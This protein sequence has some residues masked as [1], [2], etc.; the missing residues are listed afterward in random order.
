MIASPLNPG[1]P[2]TTVT[3][4]ASTTGW[5]AQWGSRHLAG[6]W[7]PAQSSLHI[8]IL[9]MTAVH[10]ALKA[11]APSL[12]GSTVA[13]YADNKTVVAHLL[14]EGGTR[15]WDLCLLTKQVF[16]LLD[17]WTITLR[18]AYL[19][20]IANSGADALSRGKEVKE[21]HLAP[22]TAK[23]LFRSWGRPNWD[24][25]ADRHNSQCR[26][27]FT[28]DR[29]DPR[30]AGVD[31]FLQDWASLQGRLY[32]F[33]PPQLV[34]QVLATMVRHK[35]NLTVIAP[36]WEDAA[37]LPELL[38][39]SRR[40][41][42]RL[43]PGSILQGP[44]GKPPPKHKELKMVAWNVSGEEQAAQGPL[45]RWHPSSSTPLEPHPN[46]PTRKPGRA[47]RHGAPPDI[48][49]QLPQL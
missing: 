10:L 49:S 17:R 23:L 5:G 24:L 26:Q 47:G 1:T 18:P 22:Q 15:A 40:T 13:W 45:R 3:S 25:F 12:K 37:W 8:N 48:W 31:A 35:V 4:D 32:A 11:W 39:L 34:P 28:L 27:Y 2:D 33:P 14:K 38:S 41:P 44:G 20:G 19:K 9:E 42:F 7:D 36:C 16:K 21:W 43:P 6:T 46:A 30:A 29:T